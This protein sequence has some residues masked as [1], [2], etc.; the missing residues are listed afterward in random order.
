MKLHLVTAL[1]LVMVTAVWGYTFLAVKQATDQYPVT[2]FIAWRFLLAAVLLAPWGLSRQGLQAG[3]PGIGCG[4][5]LAGAYFFQTYGLRQT[6]VSVAGL[7]T[8]LFVVLAPLADWMFFG[9]RPG[10]RQWFAVGLSIAGLILL[11]GRAPH[12]MGL[13]EWLT[14]G[15]AACLGGHIALLTHWSPGR[16]AAALTFWQMAVVSAVAWSTVPWENVSLPWPSPSVWT[17]II[18]CGVLASAGGFLVQTWAQQR[19]STVQTAVILSLEPVFAVIFGMVFMGDPLAGWQWLGAGLM[20][21]AA[22]VAELSPQD[23]RDARAISPDEE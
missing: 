13:G 19:L 22:L 18:V 16:S 12:E 2:A 4:L 7:V 6:S 14:L 10:R 1:L 17:A 15:G 23:Q 3:R 5:I 21:L 9:A 20:L 11:T 8:G